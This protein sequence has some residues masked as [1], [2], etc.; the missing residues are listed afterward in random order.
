MCVNEKC[1]WYLSSEFLDCSKS[2]FDRKVLERIC[3]S[4]RSDWVQA[5]RKEHDENVFGDKGSACLVKAT[6]PNEPKEDPDED[7]PN[8]E[9]V[10][11]SS[12]DGT[13]SEDANDDACRSTPA[14]ILP[15]GKLLKNACYQDNIDNT[16][17]FLTIE[18][19]QLAQMV[20][21]DLLEHWDGTRLV[22]FYMLSS[23]WFCLV[24]FCCYITVDA[25]M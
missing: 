25:W 1:T 21:R 15:S 4:K 9:D 23:L 7:D 5:W 16:S 20:P 8:D 18:V 17:L 10:K 12:G 13:C 24:F 11:N 19:Y 14:P 2:E 22:S 6:P 3:C